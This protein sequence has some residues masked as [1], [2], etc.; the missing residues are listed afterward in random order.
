MNHLKTG[1]NSKEVKYEQSLIYRVDLLR[2]SATLATL[3]TIPVF[4]PVSVPRF[5]C[6]PCNP[7]NNT[8]LSMSLYLATFATIP[9][10]LSVFVP[11]NLCN[12]CNHTCLSICLCTSQPLQPLQPFQSYLSIYM[13]LY[14]ATFATTPVCLSVYV[15]RNLCNPRNNTCL[16]LCLCTLQ[17]LQPL[18]PYQSVYRSLYIATLA[19][20][21][22]IP[23]CLSVSVPCNL[24]NL[25]NNTC[26][27]ICLCALQPLKIL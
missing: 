6:N 4:L 2:N 11:C 18:E 22:T 27:S 25:C 19:T 8:C 7:C 3:T 21:A 9:V 17:P 13:S 26:L 20:F 5:L 23:V 15:P 16:S 12:L 14:L 10:C 24:G 1:K